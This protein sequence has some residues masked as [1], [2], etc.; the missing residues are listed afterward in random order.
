MR[1]GLKLSSGLFMF[2]LLILFKQ[3]TLLEI[4]FLTMSAL[5][6]VSV[7][8][9]DGQLK[10]KSFRTIQWIALGAFVFYTLSAFM[11]LNLLTSAGAI[12]S[13][14]FYFDHMSLKAIGANAFLQEMHAYITDPNKLAFYHWQY[15]W[16]FFVMAMS[17][18]LYQIH[19]K[20]YARICFMFMLIVSGLLWF[21]Y[22]DVWLI[23][24]CFFLAF[25]MERLTRNG[26]SAL[27]GLILPVGVVVTAL[28]A[29]NLTPVESINEK[30]SPLTSENGWIRTAFNLSPGSGVF[31][32]SEMGFYPLGDRLGGPVKLTKEIVFRINSQTPNLYLRGRVL[33]LYENSQWKA[34]EHNN[35]PF[36]NQIS[37][38][39][40]V[41]HYELYDLN[42]DS[43]TVFAPMS[44]SQ[45]NLPL[46]KL[47]YGSNQEVVYEGSLLATARKGYEVTANTISFEEPLPQLEYLQLPK[48]YSK[49]VVSLTQ[50]VIRGAKTDEERVKKI[51]KYLLNNYQYAL[52]VEM[53]PEKQDFVEYF[54]T[55]ADAGYCVYFASATA[56]MARIAGL[57]SRYVEGFVTPDALEAEKGT[58]VSGERAHAWAEI[59]YNNQW[60]IVETTP[61]FTRLND[62]EV[63]APIKSDLIEPQRNAQNS[64]KETDLLMDL[65]VA[66]D[67]QTTTWKV[68]IWSWGVIFLLMLL[69]I[70]SQ[71]RFKAYFKDSS[72]LLCEKYVR[73]LLL[74]LSRHFELSH[75][76]VLTPRQIIITCDQY[77]PSLNLRVLIEIVEKSLYDSSD[78]NDDALAR[79]AEI[80]W[81]LFHENFSWASRIYWYAKI[82]IYK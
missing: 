70:I 58:P 18:L 23:F 49:A 8:W 64:K 61:T 29:T 2:G 32:L 16:L 65:P 31:Q 54:L 74:G 46:D 72:K 38:P 59:Y 35:K 73:L 67:K 22:L 41:V 63:S 60:Q 6:A 39:A 56:V 30:L 4:D 11:P 76:E 17:E 7:F 1:E 43:N 13:S 75:P 44:I 69:G 27:F 21:T 47:T 24:T 33:T 62:E 48:N 37:Q 71:V 14:L 20:E 66:D 80:Y 57:P 12:T 42:F 9:C 79:L 34:A 15:L 26:K 36:Y 25:A 19:R 81:K 40:D 53:P 10:S 5:I 52:A 77:A 3:L 78:I 82:V 45:I 28:L 55:E 68:P 50:E 51:R